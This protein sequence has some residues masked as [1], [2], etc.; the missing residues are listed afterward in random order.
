MPRVTH[1]QTNFTAGELS[2]K[3]YGRTDISRYQN[4]AKT[5]RD[6]LPEVHGGARRRDGSEYLGEVKDST[7]RVRLIP[8]VSSEQVAYVLEL[9]HLYMRFWRDGAVLGAPY[10]IVTPWTESQLYEIDYTQS[11][12]TMI[13]LHAS[14]YPQ[15]LQRP[16]DTS[17]SIG[18]VPFTSLPFVEPGAYPAATLTP[19]RKDP[20]GETITMVAGGLT[21]S[22]QSISSLAWSAGVVT[23]GRSSHGYTTGTAIAITDAEPA[24]YNGTYAITVV[25][26]HTFTYPL[27][28]SPGTATATGNCQAYAGTAVF[29]AGDVGASVKVNGGIVRLTEYVSTSVVRGVIE[30]ELTS[31]VPAP[32]DAWSLHALAWTAGNGY[33]QT[34]TF[35]E[36]RLILAGSP[37]YPQT[38]WGSVTGAPLD[39]T[40]GTNDDDAFSFAAASDQV[41]PILFVAS[42]RAL[43]ALTTGAE[44]TISGGL[45]KPLGPTNV[46][47][48]NRSNYGAAN[49][50]PVRI[51][52]AELFV[53][54]AGRKLRSF[55]YNVAS[56][57]WA[58]PDISVLAEHLTASGIVDM[59]WQQ[60]PTPTIWLVRDD[61]VLV[62]VTHDKDQDVTAWAAHTGFSGEVESI[63]TIPGDGMDEVW[64][65]VKRTVDGGVVRY[66]ERFASVLTDSAITDSADPAESVWQCAHLEGEDVDVI[67][68]GA[69]IGRFTVSGGEVD[70][71]VASLAVEIG[72]PYTSTLELLDPEIQ[73]GMGSSTGNSQRTGEITVRLH[74]TTGGAI[75][76]QALVLREFGGFDLIGTPQL[77]SGVVRVEN[78]GWERGRSPVVLTQP[79][80]MPFHV[81]SVTRKF[82]TNDG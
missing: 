8:F 68:D 61:G 26:S 6:M 31:T 30:Q 3:L 16:S 62:S 50:R 13:L 19:G 72:L 60:E 65:V 11:A 49:V 57:D 1:L 53:Q 81:L 37:A 74:E 76:G 48:R 41:N 69:Y 9:G 40:M 46:Q 58:A 38:I 79:E 39:F 42:G 17:W 28:S 45:E 75:N 25:D 52:D 56:D 20:E 4:G 34:G 80:P 59:C 10:E 77:F 29:A 24:A 54:R 47:V 2:P 27:S 43:I 23:V 22:P 63:C 66:I 5:M 51:R 32:V 14:T 21:G 73:T 71:G 35:F 7:K 64:I 55:A 78:L 70:T 36:Q 44:F 18:N 12:S 33:P 82:T 15:R 67:G